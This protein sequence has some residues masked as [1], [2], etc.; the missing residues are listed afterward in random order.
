MLMFALWWREKSKRE[1]FTLSYNRKEFFNSLPDHIKASHDPTLIT[2]T[3]FDYEGF[4]WVLDHFKGP[5]DH[6]TG[7]GK[8]DY[9]IQRKQDPKKGRPCFLDAKDCLGLIIMW[10]CTRGPTWA[11]FALSSSTRGADLPTHA[12]STRFFESFI[13]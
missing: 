2:T 1:K 10:T 11:C 8:Y 13:N 12:N 5:C 9:A 4:E 6:Y 7:L 3:G